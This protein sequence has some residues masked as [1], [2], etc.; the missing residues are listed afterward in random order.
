M[1]FPD[2]SPQD[3]SHIVTLRLEASDIT[4]V[5][6]QVQLRAWLQFPSE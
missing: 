6:L 3:Q 4:P 2:R 1:K 5:V